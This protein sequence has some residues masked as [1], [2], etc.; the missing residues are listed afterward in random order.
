MKKLSKKDR[1]LIESHELENEMLRSEMD[2]YFSEM[3][4][5]NEDK[6]FEYE[7]RQISILMDKIKMN[8][9]SIEYIKNKYKG[10]KNEK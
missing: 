7:N 9:D 1:D 3:N 10:E 6:S 2:F 4:G 5:L 8:E